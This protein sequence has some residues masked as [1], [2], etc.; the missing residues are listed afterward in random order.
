MLFPVLNHGCFTTGSRT[1]NNLHLLSSSKFSWVFHR[2]S[3]CASHCLSCNHLWIW[4][5]IFCLLTCLW[6]SWGQTLL[7]LSFSLSPVSHFK[8]SQCTQW[9]QL[10][11][12]INFSNSCICPL[13]LPH[14]KETSIHFSKTPLSG[15]D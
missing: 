13:F 7:W 4:T 14:F 10:S 12:K 9:P 15:C 3:D 1:L 8:S 5:L 11:G 6:S 2:R